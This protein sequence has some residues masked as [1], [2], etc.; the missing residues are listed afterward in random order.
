MDL[1]FLIDGFF[2]QRQE[3]LKL[4]GSKDTLNSIKTHVF[5]NEIWPDFSK[6]KLSNGEVALGFCEISQSDTLNFDGL[7]ITPIIYHIK[8]VYLEEIRHEL[9]ELSL[10]G[11]NDKILEDGD[12]IN[13]KKSVVKPFTSPQAQFE[14][15]LNINLELADEENLDEIL[16]MILT[17]T[18]ELTHS[19][20]GTL[21]MISPD[22][23]FL[24]FKVIEN[25]SLGIHLSGHN[26]EKLWDSL[27]LYLDDTTPNHTMIATISALE[28]KVINIS[29][30]YNSNEYDFEGVRAFDEKY[31][32]HSSSMLTIP[33]VN[34][35]NEV[36]GVIQLIN[37]ISNKNEATI[38]N[39]TDEKIAKIFS[40][41][42]GMVL[43][44]TQ[45][46]LSLE[47]F[48]N[49]FVSTIASAIDA[50]SKHTINHITKMA[51]L[52]PLIATSI[53]NDK[54]IYKD[55]TYSKA[56]MDEIEL[57]AKLHDIGKISMPETIMDKATKLQRIIDGIELIKDR[58]EIIKRDKE[59]LFL[60][61]EISKEQ[62][63]AEIKELDDD[64]KFIQKVNKGS[65]FMRVEDTKR[66][67]LMSK[68][69]YMREGI[70]AYLL[71]EQERYNLL[72]EKGTLT[73]EEKD[74]MNSHAQLSIDMLKVLPFPKKYQNVFH[75]AVNHHE[76]LNG[77]GY[78]RGLSEADLTLEDRI[79]I[80]ADIFEALTSHS[81]PY[82]GAMK[83]S[84]A[85]SILD[86][87][88]DRNEID[89]QMLEFFKT[90]D[91]LKQYVKE[92]LSPEQVDEF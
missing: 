51:K 1:P 3:T 57:A 72:I 10:L 42:A 56:D 2:E 27:P 60:K 33:L 34:H 82:K 48:L 58:L 25:E 14:K 71:S 73:K 64:M 45:L 88:A 12:E 19:D 61:N 54:T 44:T 87:M 89:K 18:R 5:N 65:E 46:I 20:G 22:R 29:D 36:I 74:V 66:I 91:A 81:R 41:Q 38:Y 43:T 86:A 92:E 50:K 53:S 75:I 84:E 85:F 40:R 76:K 28:N 4:Y 47:E 26:G 77:K 49:A 39:K 79:M 67:I 8:P 17:Y 32:Y 16:K 13:I 30:V 80:L 59:I 9:K 31:G 52:A 55:V 15:I 35:E 21:Y 37:K 62:F 6:I 78:P 23:K 70:K 83:L 69:T 68:Y 63:D 24:D 7:F 11:Q 90:S